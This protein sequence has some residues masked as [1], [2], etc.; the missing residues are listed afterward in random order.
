M[1]EMQGMGLEE[2]PIVHQSPNLLR[3]GRKLVYARHHIHRLSGRQ[4]MAHRANTAQTLDEDRSFPIGS[5]L[6]EALEPPELYD[7]KPSLLDLILVVE[8]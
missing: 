1:E 3:S 5:A 6:Y 7:V 2:L 4:M 8:Q